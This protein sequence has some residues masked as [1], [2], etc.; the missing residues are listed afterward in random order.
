MIWALGQAAHE[1]ALFAAIGIAIGGVDDLAMDLIWFA[2]T[3]WR[4]LTVYRRHRRA[5]AAM[6]ARQAGGRVAVFVAAWHESEVIGAMAAAALSRWAGEDVR[7]YIG[8]YPN[9]PA[10][11]RAVEQ[12]ARHDARLRL[13]INPRQGPTNKADNLNA[14]WRAMRADEAADGTEFV[15]V[16]LHDAEDVVHSA[17]I[18]IFAAL[19]RRF[20]LV[21]LPVLA[22]IEKEQ[23]IWRRF[24]SAVSADEFA[25]SHGKGLA[26]REA[27]GAAVPSAGVGCGLSRRL[28]ERMAALHGTPFDETTVTE[29]YEIGLRTGELG[30]RGVFVRVRGQGGGLVAVRAHFPDTVEAAVRQKARWQAGI[31]LSGWQRLGWRGSMAEHWMRFR[32]RRAILAALVLFCAYI[33]GV[34]ILA[35]EAIGAAPLFSATELTLFGICT[36]LML[37]RLLMRALFV[38]R[39]YGLG[40]ALASLPRVLIGNVIA[41]AAA[42]RALIAYVRLARGAPL[43]WDKTDHS[44]PSTMPNE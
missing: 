20:D 25:E 37:W 16:V 24:V 42:R 8:C 35:L 40:E 38:A 13:V 41:M 21:Q 18:G 30:G 9:D 7:L 11:I 32:D 17:E 31:A 26:V 27:L 36:G 44:F 33:S 4:W 1:L 14:L 2:R 39:I 10:T 3:I 23:G 43:V 15:A 19:C 6:I 34:M 5:D 22:L 12:V 29:D 28:L